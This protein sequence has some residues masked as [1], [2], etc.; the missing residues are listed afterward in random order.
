MVGLFS[1][2]VRLSTVKTKIADTGNNMLHGMVRN[3][4]RMYKKK[5][6]CRAD[7]HQGEAVEE[8]KRQFRYII[9]FKVYVF[10][11][12]CTEAYMLIPMTTFL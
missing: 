10:S 8:R 6:C 9:H 3:T 5:W 12:M 4:G 1:A 7:L 11:W 2:R